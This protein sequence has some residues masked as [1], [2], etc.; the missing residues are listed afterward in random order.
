MQLQFHM[1][2]YVVCAMAVQH[3]TLGNYLYCTSVS[4]ASAWHKL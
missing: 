1:Q 2:L 4:R 3:C